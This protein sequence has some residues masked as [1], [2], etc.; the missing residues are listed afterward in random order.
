MKIAIGSDHAGFGRKRE[1][2]RRLEAAGHGVHDLGCDSE[3]SCD[4]PDFA[5]AVAEAVAGGTAERGILVCGSGTGM[6]MTANRVPTVRAVQAWSVE[7]ARL[8]RQHNDANV[9]CFGA[10]VQSADETAE[11]VAAWL[12]T[13]FE[14]DRHARRVAKMG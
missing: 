10:R 12:E 11:I 3:E 8:S 5:R 14:G 13:D 9:A 1:L 6:A 2:V 7:I 4:Y